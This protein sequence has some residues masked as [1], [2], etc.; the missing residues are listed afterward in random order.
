ML[1]LAEKMALATFDAPKRF[2]ISPDLTNNILNTFVLPKA[3]GSNGDP[4]DM[5]NCI[6]IHE[7]LPNSGRI[8]RNM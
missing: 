6:K 7:N 5:E 8:R 4:D 3:V 1:S 2:T